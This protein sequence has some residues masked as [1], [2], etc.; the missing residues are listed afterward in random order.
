MGGALRQGVG[1]AYEFCLR[2]C[3]A[4]IAHWLDTERPADDIA[5]F[6]ESG[7]DGEGHL[8]HA[9]NLFLDNPELKKAHRLDNIHSWAFLGKEKATPLQAADA[10]AFEAAKEMENIVGSTKRPA[11]LSFLD[12]YR[13]ET[14]NVGWVPKQLLIEL[15]GAV[16][17]D[18]E[19]RQAAKEFGLSDKQWWID[20]KQK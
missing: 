14:D 9:F 5:Y 3:L 19:V 20:S 11:R 16:R 4:A 8:R 12:L 7:A 15:R 6:I 17:A 2:H 18:T 13:P 1:S 10:L